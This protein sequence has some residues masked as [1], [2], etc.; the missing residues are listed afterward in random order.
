MVESSNEVC[1]RRGVVLRGENNSKVIR[2]KNYK[3]LAYDLA[4]EM[5]FDVQYNDLVLHKWTNESN[6]INCV[7]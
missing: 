6:K 3:N 5:G 7:I 4:H 2:P 1:I